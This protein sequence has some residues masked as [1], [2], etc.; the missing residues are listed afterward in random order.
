MGRVCLCLMFGDER[1]LQ[2]LLREPEGR[3]GGCVD[4]DGRGGTIDATTAERW[5][6]RRRFSATK[7]PG[8]EGHSGGD[9]SDAT[10]DTGRAAAAAPGRI[11]PPVDGG[12]REGHPRPA[13]GR[14][15]TAPR[16]RHGS[17]IPL[18]IDPGG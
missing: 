9:E 18:H 13:G 7:P 11:R 12:R 4:H 1:L 6:R 5:P 15:W 3:D 2:A 16:A 17:A 8:A 10:R 14:T